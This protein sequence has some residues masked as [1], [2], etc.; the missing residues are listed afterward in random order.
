[1]TLHEYARA[2]GLPQ[3]WLKLR[4]Q[5]EELVRRSDFWYRPE[6]KDDARRLAVDASDMLASVIKQASEASEASERRKDHAG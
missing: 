1:M 4:H 6:L 5:C 3:H 2:H